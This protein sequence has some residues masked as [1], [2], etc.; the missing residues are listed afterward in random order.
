MPA[1]VPT[2]KT[3]A[4]A[5]IVVLAVADMA[6]ADALDTALDPLEAFASVIPAGLGGGV[7]HSKD[8]G[9]GWSVLLSWPMQIPLGER[10]RKQ[11]P[12]LRVVLEPIASF[13][14]ERTEL[15]IRAAP[16]VVIL[17]WQPWGLFASAGSTLR[18]AQLEPSL[19][20]ELG[21]CFSDGGAAWFGLRVDHWFAGRPRQQIALVTAWSF[22]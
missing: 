19:H 12:P 4:C 21:V 10:G 20:A 13:S 16:R 6:R 2:T 9:L 14:S 22:F 11:G 3:G 15:Q 7:T 8:G 18:L 5:L 1:I 17:P